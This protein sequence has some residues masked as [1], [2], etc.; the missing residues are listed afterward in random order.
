[1]EFDWK[2]GALAD[3]L[4]CYRS[5]EFFAAHEHWES[6]WRKCQ[7]PEKSF[8]QGL[9]QV[10]AA[11]HHLQRDNRKG[12]ASLLKSA[13]RRLESYPAIFESVE[14]RPLREEVETWLQVLAANDSPTHP[15]FP[16]IRLDLPN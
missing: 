3:G 14:V 11:F 2:L 8:I 15:S 6:V 13:L 1:M 4:Q 16:R 9:I 7:E 12:A 5:Q 10:A